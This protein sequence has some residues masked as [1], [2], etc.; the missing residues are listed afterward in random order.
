[1]TQPGRGKNRATGSVRLQR[2]GGDSAHRPAG[3][4]RA[5]GWLGR[6]AG[7]K[8]R[9][10]TGPGGQGQA[11]TGG[12]VHRLGFAPGAQ[13]HSPDR[14][15]TQRFFSYGQ[16][17]LD[18]AHPHQQQIPWQQ[19]H[20]VQTGCVRA[21]CLLRRHFVKRPH[22]GPLCRRFNRQSEAKG[23]QGHLVDRGDGVEVVKC[24]PG[25]GARQISRPLARGRQPHRSRFKCGGWRGVVR[26]VLHLF[27]MPS[28]N[29]M[30]SSGAAAWPDSSALDVVLSFNWHGLAGQPERA[31][32]MNRQLRGHSR[33]GLE[34][35][36]GFG[37]MAHG[38]GRQS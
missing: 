25:Q 21:A 37:T 35:V 1:M 12:Q 14:R 7:Q 29:P 8:D 23:V 22:D 36:S 30:E 20:L 2:R 19:P 4:G 6:R 32:L 9:R 11:S 34:F 24:L 27:H 17:G 15:A 28:D 3:L 18:I 13:Q 10:S 5:G 38:V 26:V 16:Q 31:T 33:L